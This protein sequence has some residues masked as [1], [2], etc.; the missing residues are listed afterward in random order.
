MDEHTNAGSAP[1]TNTSGEAQEM[2]STQSLL[3]QA[4]LA[5]WERRYA[6]AKALYQNAL[7]LDPGLLSGR[8]WYAILLAQQG[9]PGEAEA[10]LACALEIEPALTATRLEIARNQ[11]PNDDAILSLWGLLE[12]HRGNLTSAQKWFDLALRLNPD[13]TAALIWK[14][15]AEANQGHLDV[16][17]GLFRQAIQRRIA[18]PAVHRE[19]ACLLVKTQRYPEAVEQVEA[20]LELD[21]DDVETHQILDE[22]K[23]TL[24]RQREIN[25][26]VEIG[27]EALQAGQWEEAL[28]QAEAVLAKVPDSTE[29]QALKAEAEAAQLR[30]QIRKHLAEA[31]R[32]MAEEDYE[33]AT[34]ELEAAQQLL[35]GDEEIQERLEAV[36]EKRRTYQIT[37]RYREEARQKAQDG[38]IQG[39]L[40]LLEAALQLDP[41]SV[42]LREA[43][44][45]LVKQSEAME[46]LAQARTLARRDPSS[47]LELVSRAQGLA[48][49]LANI[50]VV[51]AEVQAQIAARREMD[52][53]LRLASE[54]RSAGQL[55]EARQLLLNTLKAHP[56]APP[57]EEALQDVERELEAKVE[58]LFNQGRQAEQSGDPEK[59]IALYE[60]AVSLL[61][62][63]TAAQDALTSLTRSLER[64]AQARRLQREAK[65]L[66]AAGEY[67]G[68]E[69]TLRRALEL[70][71]EDET[72]QSTL[73]QWE[74]E[75]AARD[76]AAKAIEYQRQAEESEARGDY[77]RAAT[78]WEEALRL[79]PDDQTIRQGHAAFAE[80]QRRREAEELATP[81][82]AAPEPALA[83]ADIA[84]RHHAEQALAAWRTGDMAEC[85][86]AARQAY[87]LVGDAI[88]ARDLGLQCG[89][90]WVGLSWASSA[91]LTEAES[92]S[93]RQATA[94]IERSDAPLRTNFNAHLLSHL[95]HAVMIK[96]RYPLENLALA[97]N[98]PDPRD[99]QLIEMVSRYTRLNDQARQELH[100]ALAARAPGDAM[101]ALVL[102]TMTELLRRRE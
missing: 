2:E 75:R 15:Q 28:Q 69:Q 72:L 12:I 8:V 26:L 92:K 46:L 59:A 85:L 7:N 96:E 49:E 13:N 4:L 101:G 24:E 9:W 60:Q 68:A 30:E 97:A 58:E 77:Q 17:E 44:Q 45:Q 16:A 18:D 79:Q 63:H 48:P 42:S 57:L 70:S 52:E 64:Q 74:Q 6:D 84:T 94:K 20:A 71:P 53:A 65:R 29:A 19:Y 11:E 35:P 80:R 25:R 88:D 37:T 27:Y 62:E 40:T 21:P 86:A 54:R 66:Y 83:E 91:D 50:E 43:H 23:A 81:P 36:E 32:L 87:E 41:E 31:D 39:A 61:P 55:S 73:R 33:G 10:E 14:A 67:A 102:H 99:R 38:D 95:T 5:H 3:E 89:L 51:K 90:V 76:R 56:D 93:L 22:V 34:A 82:P 1:M 78:F 100:E 47:A 98:T